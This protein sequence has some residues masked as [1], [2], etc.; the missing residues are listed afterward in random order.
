MIR[1]TGRVVAVEDSCLWVETIRRSTCNS[2]SAQKACG[3]GLLNKMS[4]GRTHHIR[5]LLNEHCEQVYVVNQQVDIGVPERLLVVGAM[6]IYLVPLL[7]M[8][9]GAGLASVI[10]VNHGDVIAVL[11]AVLG[12]FIGFAI[13][14]LHAVLNHNNKSMQPILLPASTQPHVANTAS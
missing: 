14:K 4:E 7:M 9:M 13:V 11:G 8:L 12:F 1:E 2:C 10:W 3:H 6:I 5:V